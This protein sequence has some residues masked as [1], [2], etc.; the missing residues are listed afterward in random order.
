MKIIRVTINYNTL[1]YNSFFTFAGGSPQNN[2]AAGDIR[3]SALLSD[4]FRDHSFV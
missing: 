1:F 4:D 3:S 2:T